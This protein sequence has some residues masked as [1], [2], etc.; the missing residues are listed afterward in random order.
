[1]A[2]RSNDD[3]NRHLENIDHSLAHKAENGWKQWTKI[4]VPLFLASIGAAVAIGQT[5]ITAQEAYDTS[6]EN[7]EEL[8][9]LENQVGSVEYRIEV[10]DDSVTSVQSDFEKLDGTF[11]DFE[12]LNEEQYNE[13]ID[14][15][16]E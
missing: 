6:R 5:I 15:I 13:I 11:G 8:T 9:E 2:D 4:L 14:A 1:M 12:D 3:I 7:R 16:E 10:L